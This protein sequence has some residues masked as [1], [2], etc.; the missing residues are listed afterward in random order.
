MFL[1]DG[2]SRSSAPPD[3]PQY[4]NIGH[5]DDPDAKGEYR[6]VRIEQVGGPFPPFSPSPPNLCFHGSPRR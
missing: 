1:D 2:T 3:L 4:T 5:P 6:E